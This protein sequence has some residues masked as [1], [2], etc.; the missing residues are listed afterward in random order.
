MKFIL[1]LL[2]CTICFVPFAEQAEGNEALIFD[3]YD[4]SLF[5]L[6]ENI[7]KDAKCEA[8]AIACPA[9]TPAEEDFIRQNG[10]TNNAIFV[11]EIHERGSKVSEVKKRFCKNPH[12]ISLSY[13]PENSAW[14]FGYEVY[15]ELK[16]AQY[17]H[18]DTPIGDYK[19]PEEVIT[20]IKKSKVRKEI[21]G[22]KE[23][24]RAIKTSL[25]IGA[26]EMWL[27]KDKRM[28]F[29]W[30]Y[31]FKLTFDF[32]KKILKRIWYEIGTSNKWS[33]G[34]KCE[35]YGLGAE[36]YND[37][38]VDGLYVNSPVVLKTFSVTKNLANT[39]TKWLLIPIDHFRFG[40][41]SPPAC[42][43]LATIPVWEQ[44]VEPALKKVDGYLYALYKTIEEPLL[45]ISGISGELQLPKNKFMRATLYLDPAGKKIPVPKIIYKIVEYRVKDCPFEEKLCLY[46]I[47]IVIHNDILFK[48][49]DKLC[50][51]ITSDAQWEAISLNYEEQHVDF[52]YACE[53]TEK[54]QK[55]L[56]IE[57]RTRT[58]S[59]LNLSTFPFMDSTK[60]ALKFLDVKPAI[61]SM[62]RDL[63]KNNEDPHQQ[64]EKITKRVQASSTIDDPVIEDEFSEEQ[65]GV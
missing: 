25:G 26:K 39:I 50:T 44:K 59:K 41:T 6:P 51:D 12:Q 20:F 40:F 24:Y 58:V 57:S 32:S 22:F 65:K 19:K 34:I 29:M 3:R 36:P 64:D 2:I 46:S 13:T 35:H 5:L 30:L 60:T 48:P 54:L 23:Y 56:S 15:Y 62:Y 31:Y 38:G 1:V 8:W 28:G 42:S 27:N 17:F 52:I 33:V 4:G 37:F 14:Q 7:P 10:F 61:N 16:D 55:K 47:I 18:Q 63:R 53:N 43:N 45:I 49:S 9:E 21:H 11:K